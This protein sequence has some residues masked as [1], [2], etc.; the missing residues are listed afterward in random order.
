MCTT[1]SVFA[2]AVPVKLGVRLFEGVVGAVSVTTGEVVLTSKVIGS[3]LP[4]PLPSEL[5]SPATG[6]IGGRFEFGG[7]I[8]GVPF[9]SAGNGGFGGGDHGAFRG[10]ALVDLDHDVLG[11]GAVPLNDGLVR[12]RGSRRV[13][14]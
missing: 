1:T 13:R 14:A 4:S 5:S 10:R 8:G 12:W 11:F 6:G 9:A 7:E 3:L 2:L